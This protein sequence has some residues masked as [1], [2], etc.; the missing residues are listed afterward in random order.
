MPEV[1]TQP[2]SVRLRGRV[3]DLA[4][5]VVRGLDVP[6]A[7]L[8]LAHRPGLVALDSAS[9]APGRWS[10][11][12]FDPLEQFPAPGPGGAR[13]KRLSEQG[14]GHQEGALPASASQ[15]PAAGARPASLGDL[16]QVLDDVAWEG[17]LPPGPFCGGFIGA[18]AYDLGV[19]GEVLE[20]PPAAWPQPP[21][22]GGLY[23][24]W[25]VFELDESGI[26]REAHLVVADRA[27]SGDDGDQRAASVLEDLGR[28]AGE[29]EPQSPTVHRRH[30][31]SDEHQGRV[32]QARA[33]IGR[34]EIYQ[35]NICH[36]MTAPVSTGPLD[37]YLELRRQ[38]PAPYMGYLGFTF[39]DGALGAI[40]SSSPELMLEL[41]ARG[42]E[43]RRARTRPIKGTIACGA[44]AASDTL[45]RERLLGSEKDRAELAMIV[46][47][48]RN[49][50]GR[51]SVPGGVTVGEFPRLETY[52]G[53]HHLV[54]DVTG[55][56]RPECSAVDV[57]AALFP[58]GSITGAPKLRSMEA[59]G[60]IEGEGRGF[61]TGSMGFIDLQGRATFNILIRTL[62]HRTGEDGERE[63]SFHVGGG[64]TWSSDAKAEDDETMLKAS[65]MIAA[66]SGFALPGRP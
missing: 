13:G 1:Q 5:L 33:L 39:P 31:S 22:A 66:L 4:D 40:L 8:R 58:G 12:A 28:D 38:N 2:A 14:R 27:G 56:V 9:G 6:A 43:G 62:I 49:D 61:F 50:L 59:I 3:V 16:R 42:V 65:A 26:V 21:I 17:G 11:V 46:D 51:I 34:G 45:Q 19:E 47:L 29:P 64:I 60:E 24:D 54:T 53:L 48:E 36:R 55:E 44:D 35:A 30:V 7:L 41:E 18:I 63:V 25:L 15:D 10:L 32:E 52:R 37:L 20:L 57:V 23:R